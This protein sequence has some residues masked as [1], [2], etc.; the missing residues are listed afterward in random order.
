LWLHLAWEGSARVATVPG[1]RHIIRAW[2]VRHR[3]TGDDG[4]ILK[5]RR[6]RIRTTHEAMRHKSAWWA[7]R[8]AAIDPNHRSSPSS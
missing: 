7:S 6:D 4:D 8:R 2:A 5:I 1:D 3:V